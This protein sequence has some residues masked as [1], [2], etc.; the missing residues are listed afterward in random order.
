MPGRSYRGPLDGDAETAALAAQ[1][2][3]HVVQL[4]G[5]IGERNFDRYRQLDRAAGYISTALEASGCKPELQSYAVW[6]GSVANIEC[7]L[8][9]ETTPGEIV[10]IGA[11]YDSVEGSP[12]AN[13]NASGVAALL[14]LAERFGELPRARTLRFVAFA[15]EEPPFFQTPR[16]GSEVY[17]ERVTKEPGRVVAMLSLETIGCYSDAR[18]SQAYPPIFRWFYPDR[19]DF[20][21]LVAN[22]WSRSLLHQ[23]IRTFRSSGAAVASEGVAAPAFIEGVAWSD[24]WAFWRRDVPALMVTD[25]ALFRYREYHTAEDTPDRLDYVRMASVV[26]GLVPVVRELAGSS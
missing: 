20:I 14:E 4:A 25:T 5:E 9:G 8:L 10:V 11:H 17:A 1:L 22:P 7:E 2:R 24:Q 15:N 16:M 21:A 13:D 19:G 6:E 23:A 26:E 18:G 3:E 12:G